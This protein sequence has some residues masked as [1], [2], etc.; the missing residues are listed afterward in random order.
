MAMHNVLLPSLTGLL[1]GAAHVLSGPDHLA[2]IA[3]LAVVQRRQTWRLGFLWGL[4]H[5]GGVWILA[6]LAMVFREILPTDLLSAWGE[7]LVGFVLVGIGLLGLRRLFGTRVHSHVHEHGGLRHVHVH[8]H[9]ENSDHRHPA[10]HTHSHIALGVGALH[11]LAGASHLLGVLPALLLPTRG[12]AGAYV[13]SF[14]LGSIV[15]MTAFS[16]AMGM[17]AHHLQ[18]WG[19]RVFRLLL[20]GCCALSIAIGC[21]WCATTLPAPMIST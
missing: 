11:G 2:A 15:A 9:A 1:A 4:G 13:I 3:P 7:R 12:A 17:I 10:E 19:D 20:G 5:S 8:L 21:Y 18:S 14:G 16:W 6:L